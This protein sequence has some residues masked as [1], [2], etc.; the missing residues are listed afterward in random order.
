MESFICGVWQDI[1]TK[2]RVI[3]GFEDRFVVIIAA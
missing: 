2:F 1:G 3:D